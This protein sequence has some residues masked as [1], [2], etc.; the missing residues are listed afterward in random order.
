MNKLIVFA[1]LCL[2]LCSV[3]N[4]VVREKKRGSDGYKFKLDLD[5]ERCC[6][7]H[8]LDVKN[9][10]KISDALVNVLIASNHAY[11]VLVSLK[12]IDFMYSKVSY[13]V[14]A[15][16]IKDNDF[17]VE[18]Y[19]R[20]Q[21]LVNKY[22]ICGKVCKVSSTLKKALRAKAANA[23]V[24]H[25]DNEDGS[26]NISITG[27][28]I[29]LSDIKHELEDLSSKSKTS[30]IAIVANTLIIDEDLDNE[31]W[32]SNTIDIHVGTLAIPK[33]V[34]WDLRGAIGESLNLSRI[35][36]EFYLIFY[37]KNR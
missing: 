5:D 30:R 18:G 12:V 34:T 19:E 26:E 22:K 35:V 16:N 4:A 10:Q 29:I 11:D 14:F 9:S 2:A 3:A 25:S 1:G 20:L 36:S 31:I 27:D 8:C 7:D 13:Q 23:Q 21:Q 37:L 28:L 6:A 33:S 24:D 17:D 15:E 32:H